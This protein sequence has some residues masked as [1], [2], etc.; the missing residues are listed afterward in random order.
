M[1]PSIIYLQLSVLLLLIKLGT[2]SRKNDRYC[3]DG[4]IGDR[5][6]ETIGLEMSQDKALS[7]FYNCYSKI[8]KCNMSLCKSGM[9]PTKYKS[10]YNR[11]KLIDEWFDQLGTSHE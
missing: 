5:S 6:R 1:H 11:K 10:L 9:L 3:Y 8:R 2:G 4:F 7:T